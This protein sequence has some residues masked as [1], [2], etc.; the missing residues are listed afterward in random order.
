MC[1]TCRQ[2]PI[3]GIRWKCAECGNYDL[4][5][6]CYHG[7]KHHLRHRFY[8]IATPGS[9]RV[10]LEPR[11]KSK[12]VLTHCFECLLLL[13]LHHNSYFI[14]SIRSQF[15]EY[16]LVQGLSEVLI[17]NGKIKM[18]GMDEGVKLTKFKIGQQPVHVQLLM[19]YGIMEQ[20]ICIASVLKEWLVQN[21]F[22]CAFF[23]NLINKGRLY[24]L[25]I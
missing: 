15:A 12:K 24:I 6:I 23:L 7:D 22:N 3:F 1:D 11:R 20:K 5:S 25:E 8:R 4:C 9:E 2:Q 13:L 16:F 17:G 19:L 18:A 10:L 14:F 21:N